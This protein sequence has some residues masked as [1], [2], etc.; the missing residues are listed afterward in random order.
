MRGLE[1]AYAQ[2]PST[3]TYL[4]IPDEAIPEAQ[5]SVLDY[6]TSKIGGKLAWPEGLGRPHLDCTVCKSQLVLALTIYAP[7]EASEYHR[8]L[9]FFTCIRGAHGWCCLRT[10]VLSVCKTAKEDLAQGSIISG[11]ESWLDGADDWGEA[12]AEEEE[13]GRTSASVTESVDACQPPDEMVLGDMAALSMFETAQSQDLSGEGDT[14]AWVEDTEG[15]S[16]HGPIVLESDMLVES[17]DIPDLLQASSKL[18]PQADQATF[19][20]HP[21]YISVI[22]EPVLASKKEDDHVEGKTRRKG[23][24]SPG[25]DAWGQE[26]YEKPAPRHGDSNFYHFIQVVQE[27]NQ[28]KEQIIRTITSPVCFLQAMSTILLLTPAVSKAK[29]VKRRNVE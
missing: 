5:D 29:L 7:L 21:R 13:E 9:Y 10:Q 20:F 24:N 23:K 1:A 19:T 12:P 16:G 11:V 26:S 14:S 3:R 18:P 28:C 22:E 8:T 4:G 17:S 15:G 6:T 25:S 27:H 2:M